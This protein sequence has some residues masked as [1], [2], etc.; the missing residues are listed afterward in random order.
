MFGSFFRRLHHLTHPILG[1]IMMLHRVVGQR[2]IGENRKLEITPDFLEQTIK[3]YK[4][5]GCRFVSIDE[6]SEILE[7]GKVDKPF[8]C[9]TFDDGYHD[10][11]TNA[12]PILKKEQVP[13]AIY[14][15]TGFVDNKQSMWW[16]PNER[17]GLSR[18]ELLNLDAEPLCTICAHTNTHPKLENLSVQEQRV[19]IK[20]SKQDLES[21]LGHPVD[22]FSYP[23][24]SYNDDTIGIIKGCDFRT[25]LMAWGGAVRKGDDSLQLHRIELRQS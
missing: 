23:H 19:E 14:V 24:G 10:N 12:L 18:D 25:A 16:Y 22:H 8:V 13:F 7:K 3:D 20:Q 1:R 15:T 2:S 4:Q 11:Y 21:L 5:K 17:L 9:L 6:V